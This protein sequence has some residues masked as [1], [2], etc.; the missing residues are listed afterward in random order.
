MKELV[1]RHVE[2][3]DLASLSIV[4]GRRSRQMTWRSFAIGEPGS[5][6]VFSVP[7][8]VPRIPNSVVFIFSGQ[9]PQHKDSKFK[10]S[11]MDISDVA[12]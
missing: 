1:E 12:N 2:E 11:G 4:L 8:F 3:L 7:H 9:G 5:N 6:T 10:P